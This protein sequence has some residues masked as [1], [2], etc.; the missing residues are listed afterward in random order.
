MYHAAVLVKRA[1]LSIYDHVVFYTVFDTHY[2]V[3]LK[4]II[5]IWQY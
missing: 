1:H 2:T 4:S 3:A 5:L